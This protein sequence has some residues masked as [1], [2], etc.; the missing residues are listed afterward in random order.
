MSVTVRDQR[1]LGRAHGAYQLHEA[2][3]VSH[4]G[5]SAARWPGMGVALDIEFDR[6]HRGESGH[7]GGAYMALVRTGVNRDAIGAGGD[8]TLR[9][10]QQVRVVARSRVAYQR[11]FIDVYRERDA[12]FTRSAD[13]ITI[14]FFGTSSMPAVVWVM[15]SEMPSTTSMPSTT[16]PK[17]V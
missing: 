8:D 1:A 13:S 6:E 9:V 12:H 2:R 14:G 10:A 16:R 3:V 15:T 7:I 5:A 17:T 11:D 4:V